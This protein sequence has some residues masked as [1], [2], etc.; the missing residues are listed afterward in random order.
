MVYDSEF[1]FVMKKDEFLFFIKKPEYNIEHLIKSV[2]PEFY[3]EK[4]DVIKIRK[5]SE[6]YGG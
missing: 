2:F 1:G 6:I 5:G 4:V 3:K